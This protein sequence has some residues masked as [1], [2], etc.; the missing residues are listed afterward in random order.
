MLGFLLAARIMQMKKGSSNTQDRATLEIHRWK[1]QM[2][3]LCP[4]LC[5]CIP[6]LYVWAWGHLAGLGCLLSGPSEAVLSSQGHENKKTVEERREGRR[7]FYYFNKLFIILQI[8]KLAWV[9][10]K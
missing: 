8:P 6:F 5:F 2:M 4:A 1:A 7:G 9:L 3:T 10:A